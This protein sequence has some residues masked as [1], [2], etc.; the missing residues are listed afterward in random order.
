ME[1]RK[2][3]EPLMGK[4]RLGIVLIHIRG[5]QKEGGR[6]KTFGKNGLYQRIPTISGKGNLNRLSMGGGGNFPGVFLLPSGGEKRSFG[7]R[8]KL[9]FREVRE[10]DGATLMPGVDTKTKRRV[11]LNI[12]G[13][14]KSHT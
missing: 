6:R 7:R 3:T 10:V 14:F 13:S 9:L 5:G 12:L 8:K 11:A 1:P 4:E 2:K